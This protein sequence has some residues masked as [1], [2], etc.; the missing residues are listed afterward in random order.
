[1]LPS[2]AR[3]GF[4]LI[5][6][7]VVIAIIAILIAL[8]LPA[9]QQAR[10]AARRTQ[11]KNNLK[12]LGLAMHNYHDTHRIFP[13]EA[14]YAYNAGTAASPS[15]QPRNHTWVSMMLPFLDQG[16]LYNQINFALPAWNQL[17]TD[18]TK[19]H[20]KQLPALTCPSDVGFAGPAM[21]G[22]IAWTNY[23]VPEGYDWWDRRGTG[24]GGMFGAGM[25]ARIAELS[26]GT[27][28]TI[29]LGE[30]TAFGFQDGF[31]R[32]GGGKQ[33][34]GGANAVVRAAFI[35]PVVD[36]SP[37]AWGYPNPDGSAGGGWWSK[38]L[39]P[40]Y[41]HV[42]KPTYLYTCALNGDWHGPNSRH[43]GGAHFGMADGSVRFISEN[44]GYQVEATMTPPNVSGGGPWG[45]LNTYMG[46]EVIGEF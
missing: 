35:A 39:D 11:C 14:F 19:F 29:M 10:E 9:V 21:L 40:N 31:Q 16:P 27:S 41:P 42:F 4:T 1:M 34:P 20:A 3:R 12:Q 45:A 37:L 17:M 44:I 38:T 22:D 30:A 36:G 33:R 28:N 5:E 2:R 43:E 8:L 46:G 32:N 18:G 7:L 13:S 15:W 26:D 6:L 23:V 24:M 25:S